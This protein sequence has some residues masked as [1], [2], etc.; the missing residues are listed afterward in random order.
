M[1]KLIHHVS[2]ELYKTLC[3]RSFLLC[4]IITCLLCFT[5]TVYT[6]SLDGKEYTVLEI[7]TGGSKFD[8]LSFTSY[9]ILQ[10][11][12]NPYV[13]LFLPVLSSI[14]FV[15]AFCAERSC[16]NIRFT[17]T[18]IGK[19]RYCIVKFITALLS[20]GTA[21]LSGYAVFGLLICTF[22]PNPEQILSAYI[23]F[24]IG[25]GIYGAVSVLPA[26]L[27]SPFTANQYIICCFPF[28][29]MNFYFI[30]VA[31][32]Q[33][34]LLTSNHP[35]LFMKIDFLY[36]NVL[37]DTLFHM[38]AGALVY[39]AVLTIAVFTGFTWVMNRRLDYGQ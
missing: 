18:R 26:F 7:I 4:A 27:L 21:V 8:F 1:K 20:G 25:M 11:S 28:I 19:Y 33:S 38:N 10:L 22:F 12:V 23:K 32:I 24:L 15:T 17:V 34:M 37:K 13:T 14:P 2:V 5:S 3:N 6:D 16:G 30:A 35:D 9:D 36:P 29:F 39:H 31:K